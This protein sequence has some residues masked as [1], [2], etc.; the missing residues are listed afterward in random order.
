MFK[1]QR[2]GWIFIKTMQS[3]RLF[4]S[5]WFIYPHERGTFFNFK[6]L[7]F[8]ANLLSWWLTDTFQAHYGDWL[9]VSQLQVLSAKQSSGSW[10]HQVSNKLPH[11]LPLLSSMPSPAKKWLKNL[12]KKKVTDYWEQKIGRKQL[13]WNLWNTFIHS[14]C[15][16]N[17]HILSSYLLSP[18]HMK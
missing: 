8:W 10:F 5:T 17:V 12:A 3:F 11:P 13:H 7:C 9:M 14:L 2:A 15:P 4:S 6:F 18:L 1:W 16:L